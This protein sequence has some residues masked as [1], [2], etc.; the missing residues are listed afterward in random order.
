MLYET[1]IAKIPL[2]ELA[3]TLEYINRNEESDE[4]ADAE[5]KMDKFLYEINARAA[6]MTKSV[7]EVNIN[8][9]E[10][11]GANQVKFAVK[12]YGANQVKF[13]MAEI[14][15]NEDDEPVYGLGI[16]ALDDDGNEIASYNAEIG[17]DSVLVFH[18]VEG[19][20]NVL[21]HIEQDNKE[22]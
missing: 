9:V 21:V 11:Y 7:K 8:F 6:H 19:A 18:R 14:D 5:N 22:D 2:G 3:E 10:V 15:T 12:V 4:R 1:I 16:I 17:A 13:A 20:C